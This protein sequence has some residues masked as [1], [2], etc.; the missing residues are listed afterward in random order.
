MKQVSSSCVRLGINGLALG[1]TSITVDILYP[2]AA[3]VKSTRQAFVSAS[4]IDH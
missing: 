1:F 3:I 2:H 4:V